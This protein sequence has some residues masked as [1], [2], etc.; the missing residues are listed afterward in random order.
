MDGPHANVPQ[1]QYSQRVIPV[2]VLPIFRVS[3]RVAPCQVIP[4]GKGG[5]VNTK[6]QPA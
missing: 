2:C 1:A 5:T 3:L 4:Y 6:E